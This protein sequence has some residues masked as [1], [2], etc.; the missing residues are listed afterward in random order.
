MLNFL[1]IVERLLKSG[2][3]ILCF[4]QNIT[5]TKLGVFMSYKQRIRIAIQEPQRF[6]KA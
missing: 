3:T 2:I 4:M 6:Q 5:K 1:I